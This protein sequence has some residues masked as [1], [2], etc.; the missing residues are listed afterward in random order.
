M[1]DQILKI[2]MYINPGSIMECEDI[3]AE[4][5]TMD[6]S[7]SQSSNI[8]FTCSMN[9]LWWHGINPNCKYTAIRRC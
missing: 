8:V 5:S 6:G 3:R 9:V 7:N 4:H 2:M 1:N